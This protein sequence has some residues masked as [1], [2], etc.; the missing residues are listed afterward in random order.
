MRLKTLLCASLAIVALEI[1]DV[2][3][4]PAK[5][6]P[7]MQLTEQG[8]KL[9]ASYQAMLEEIRQEIVTAIPKI[10]EGKKN[11]YLQAQ[12]DEKAAEK[13]L[14]DA[15][16]AL[17]KV[18]GAAGLVAHAK[19]KWIGGAD[20]GIAEAKAK[21][22]KAQ[23][24][25][26]KEAA[27]KEL[28]QWQKNREDGVK[29]LVEREAALAKAKEDEPKL[30]AEADA[31]EKAFAES[32]K[33]TLEATAALGIEKFL[34]SDTLDGKLAKFV[35]LNEATPRGLAAF[36]EQ[37]DA[38]GTLVQHLLNDSGLMKQMVMNDGAVDGKYGQAMKIYTDIVQA[39]PKAKAGVLHELALAVALEHAVPVKQ[40]NP[41]AAT[42]ARSTVDPV[43]RYREFAKAYADGELDPAFAKFNAWDLRFVV[44]GDEPEGA[45]AWGRTMLRNYRPDQ[46]STSDYAWRYVESVRSD[47]RYGSQDLKFDR[48]DLFSYQ[49][50]IMNGGICGRRAFFGR[51]IL[52]SFGIPTTARPQTGHAALAHWT[53]EGWVVN[54]G[55]AWG[56]GRTA[57]RYVSDLDFLATTQARNNL[58]DYLQ[59]KRAQWIGD[60]VG[61]KPVYG[62][63]AKD[64]PGF[65]YGVSLYCQQQII[66]DAKAKVLAA[67]GEDIG[68]ANESKIPEVVKA[69]KITDAD[70]KI[71]VAAGGTITIPAAATSKPTNSTGKIRFMPSVLG[72]MQLHYSRGGGP[73]EFEYT[74]EAPAAGDYTLTAK[75]VTTSHQQHLLVSANDAS[76]PVTIDVPHTVGKW[77]TTPAVK[78]ALAKGK[79]VLRFSHKA[80]GEPKGVTI[81]EFTLV[82]AK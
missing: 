80:S 66:A 11:A 43:A 42:D 45:H 60:A 47:V 25:A 51:F 68:E 59:V 2:H 72:G 63:L 13:R 82:P 39:D 70:R 4:K 67:V 49:N 76:A 36:A 54:L 16:A 62:L 30:K 34:A 69:A 46:V 73:E 50:M 65:W 32:K 55:A 81:K 35:V 29:A 5:A 75:V 15:Q 57:T 18:A 77:E 10:D 19:G 31:A 44:N 17:G 24:P 28:A 6:P 71:T 78:V 48:P 58:T 41:V 56:K 33:R 12:K 79:N 9:A 22:A 1:S 21:L 64:V 74:F 61:E 38:N 40:T 52:R 27:E 23:S 7:A 20:K 37:S 8:E 26:D 14:L 3:A 53:P